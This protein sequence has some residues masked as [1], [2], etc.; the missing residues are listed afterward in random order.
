MNS[1][2]KMKL[3]QTVQEDLWLLGLR[4]NQS[5]KNRELAKTWLILILATVCGIAF[6]L[7]EAKTFQEYTMS[8]YITSSIVILDASLT[9]MILKK[10]AFLKW[11]R[12]W[13]WFSIK[14]SIYKHILG[15]CWKHTDPVQ[16]IMETEYCRNRKWS[17]QRISKRNLSIHRKDV[18]NWTFHNRRSNARLLHFSESHLGLLQLLYHG[19]G[20][21]CI[22]VATVAMVIWWIK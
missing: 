17:I 14:V 21:C 3:F 6:L 7:F 2:L 19:V 15:E 9:V 5:R 1:P 11:S 18:S 22:W 16:M 8:L 4:S 10:E 12:V 20:E 13:K